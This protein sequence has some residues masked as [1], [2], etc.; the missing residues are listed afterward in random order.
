MC[1]MEREGSICLTRGGSQTN[2]TVNCL[3]M[4]PELT[5]LP[6]GFITCSSGLL[7]SDEVHEKHDLVNVLAL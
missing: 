7:L 3:L 5:R 1:D 2:T 4:E 6:Q